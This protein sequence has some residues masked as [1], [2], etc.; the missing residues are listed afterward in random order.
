MNRPLR[1]VLASLGIYLAVTLVVHGFD[2]PRVKIKWNGQRLIER[3]DLETAPARSLLL[4]HS[5]P[6]ALNGLLILCIETAKIAGTSVDA[7]A[8]VLLS[9]LNIGSVA[10]L[11]ALVA[12]A[13]KSRRLGLLTAIAATLDPGFQYYRLWFLAASLVYFLV[14]AILFLA[15][16]ALASGQRRWLIA[17]IL[18]VPLLPNTKSMFHPTWALAFVGLLVVFF[19]KIHRKPAFSKRSEA[20]LTSMGFLFFLFAWPVKNAILFDSFTFSTWA[21]FNISRETPIRSPILEKY[22]LDGTI[23]PEVHEDIERFSRRFGEHQLHI[24][25]RPTRANG[26]RN[27]N[28]YTFI[29]TQ[30]ELVHRALSYRMNHPGEWFRSGFENYQLW[31]RAT[32]VH[33]Y[34]ERIRGT[35]DGWYRDFVRAV[36][37]TFFFD[38]G[39]RWT[40]YGLL[41]FPGLLA[42]VSVTIASDLRRGLE[43]ETGLSILCLFTI[44][45]LLAVV[46]LTDGAEGN[47]LRFG[48]SPCV[49]ALTATVFARGWQTVKVWR[50][51]LGRQ[52]PS[53]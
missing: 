47:R 43:A 51:R 45:W 49:L 40:P 7:P 14:A 35:W 41:L 34:S 37:A 6:P 12:A 5:Q 50:T 39:S 2:I 28:H 27:R 10:L 26:T 11:F 52:P 22:L 24:L 17:A 9:A 48:I 29:S 8:T 20:L 38:T 46:C 1:T 21:G 23:S 18:A 36:R 31:T 4:L 33:P 32:F 15:Y 30:E 3:T 44:L 16:K 25:T 13:T 42:L 53:S 19:V